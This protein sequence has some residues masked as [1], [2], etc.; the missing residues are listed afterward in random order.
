MIY[1]LGLRNISEAGAGS[2]ALCL[3]LLQS[4]S[5]QSFVVFVCAVF[6]PVGQQMYGK[7]FSK[8]G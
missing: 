8:T 4:A 5:P 3:F 1:F 6:K 2:L 7:K